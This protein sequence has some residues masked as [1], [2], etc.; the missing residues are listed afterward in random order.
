MTRI[1][2]RAG[3]EISSKINGNKITKKS[4]KIKENE[5]EKVLKKNN[6]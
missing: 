5:E 1:L 4:K 6:F 2:Y 3:A